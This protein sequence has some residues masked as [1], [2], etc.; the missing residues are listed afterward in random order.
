MTG[1]L[2]LY[3]TAPGTFTIRLSSVD[4]QNSGYEPKEEGFVTGIR[5]DAIDGGYKVHETAFIRMG[6]VH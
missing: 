3:S 4:T 1:W 6:S 5:I 2:H